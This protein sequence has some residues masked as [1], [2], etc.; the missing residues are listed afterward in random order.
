MWCIFELTVVQVY[1][2]DKKQVWAISFFLGKATAFTL[3]WDDS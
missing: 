1:M 2:N 3:F